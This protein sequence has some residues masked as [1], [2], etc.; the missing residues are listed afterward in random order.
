LAAF[1]RRT[2]RGDLAIKFWRSQL[3]GRTDAALRNWAASELALQADE[4]P[5]R[6]VWICPRLA[7][8]P[9]L[10]GQLDDT[11]WQAVPFTSLSSGLAGPTSD[12]ATRLKLAYDAEF[13]Y[14]AAQADKLAGVTYERRSQPRR[15]DQALHEDRIEL[16]LDV[17]RDA[18]TSWCLTVDHQGRATERLNQDTSWNPQ[19]YVASAEG[20]AQWTVEAAV[21]LAALSQQPA[22]PRTTWCLGIQRITPGHDWETWLQPAPVDK[23]PAEF[24][25]LRFE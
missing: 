2:G 5:A 21:P 22:T 19:W 14:V 25:L 20:A 4:L 9:R 12:S 11:V 1:Q 17:D 23:R 8:P 16:Y 10:D 13:L 3:V 18:M 24:G 15:R 6:P 7:N